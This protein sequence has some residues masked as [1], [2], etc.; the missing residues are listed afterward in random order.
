MTLK[1][2]LLLSSIATVSLLA[3]TQDIASAQVIEMDFRCAGQTAV[4]PTQATA[5]YQW[6]LWCRDHIPPTLPPGVSTIAWRAISWLTTDSIADYND[7]IFAGVRDRLFPI[8]SRADQLVWNA[9][10][11]A[12]AD[13]SL[14]TNYV[15]IGLCVAGCYTEDTPLQFAEGSIA[16]KSAIDLGKADLVTL[17]PTATLDNLQYVTNQVHRYSADLQEDWQV[18]HALTMHSGGSL[19]VTSEHPLL[20]SDGI[21]RQAKSLKVGDNLLLANGKPDPIVKIA[22]NK[23]FVKVYNV[24][25]VTIDYTTNIVVAGGYLNGSGRYQNEF[26][27]MVNALILRRA[28]TDQIDEF[29]N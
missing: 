29:A 9:P 13:C 12:T 20:T 15:N 24:K 21:I 14:K 25:P 18:I 23:M 1:N 17:A 2:R 4:S 11:S 22:T 3:S 26:L 6:A 27:N 28:I 19:R 7:P 5:R 10:D 8:Y 16:I